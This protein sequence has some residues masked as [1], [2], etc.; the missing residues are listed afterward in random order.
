MFTAAP[1][2]G[3]WLAMLTGTIPGTTLAAF[4]ADTHQ[5]GVATQAPELAGLRFG[6]FHPVGFPSRHLTLHSIPAG[7]RV[8]RFNFN[9]GQQ[10]AIHAA[11]DAGDGQAPRF[12]RCG[13]LALAPAAPRAMYRPRLKASMP[14]RAEHDGGW[15]D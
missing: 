5:T 9:N 8:A 15:W 11:V 6:L 12:L 3:C 1:L 2:D 10:P 4:A 13:N 14:R 7:Q